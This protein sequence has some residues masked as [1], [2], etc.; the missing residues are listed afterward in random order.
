MSIIDLLISQFVN[1][2]TDNFLGQLYVVLNAILML[3]ATLASGE[4]IIGGG[5]F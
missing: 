4:P 3:F 1:I 5:L 2:P